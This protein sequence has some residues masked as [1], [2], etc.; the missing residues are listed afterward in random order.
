VSRGIRARR[1]PTRDAGRTR[2]G[3]RA[4]RGT[5]VSTSPDSV[6]R[7][8]AAEALAAYRDMVE[9]AREQMSRV[10]E[11]VQPGEDLWQPRVSSFRAGAIETEEWEHV[12]ALAQP[13]ATWLDIGA[14]AGRCR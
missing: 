1:R 4:K 7:P 5:R 12:V 6:L 3:R 14:G 8:G 10:A 11:N 13:G 9:R 2:G